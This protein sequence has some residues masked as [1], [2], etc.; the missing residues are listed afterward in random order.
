[1]WWYEEKIYK[2]QFNTYEVLFMYEIQ[3][4][5]SFSKTDRNLS[6]CFIKWSK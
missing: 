5:E 3:I 1:M 6:D 4:K 2:L